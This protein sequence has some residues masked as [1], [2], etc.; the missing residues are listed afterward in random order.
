LA[1]VT[2]WGNNPRAWVAVFIAKVF[3]Q[4]EFGEQEYDF[5]WAAA[6]EVVQSMDASLTDDGVELNLGRNIGG[7]EDQRRILGKP[8]VQ[9]FAWDVIAIADEPWERDL[10]GT[11]I[12]QRPHTGGH[13]AWFRIGITATRGNERE[14]DTV[15]LRVFRMKPAVFV[16]GVAHSA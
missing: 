4:R 15:D 11:P 2:N 7:R 9:S 14:G 5:V 13:G 6:L 3:L 8:G 1:I 16:Y 10:T 12:L